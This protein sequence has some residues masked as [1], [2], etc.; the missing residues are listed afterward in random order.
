M[1]TQTEKW[2]AGSVSSYTNTAASTSLID[3]LANLNAVI[4]SDALIASTGDIYMD[5]SFLLASITAGGGAPSVDWF[6]FPQNK[7]SSYGDGRAWTTAGGLAAQP[8]TEYQIWSSSFPPSTTIALAGTIREVRVPPL[9][10]FKLCVYNQAGVA[11][12]TGNGTTTNII[13]YKFYDRSLQ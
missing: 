3:T 7:D 12:G 8:P 13:Q 2:I 4:C 6:L 1:T 11:L 5:I 10:N 9:T